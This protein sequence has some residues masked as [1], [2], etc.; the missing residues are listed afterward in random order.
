MIQ[1]LP[2][3]QRSH[4]P[5]LGCAALTFSHFDPGTALT[6]GQANGDY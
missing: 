5:C 1:K 2:A 6:L 3:P 4:L